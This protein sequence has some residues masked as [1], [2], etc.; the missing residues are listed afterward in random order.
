MKSVEILISNYN[1]GPVIELNIESIRARTDYPNYSIIVHDDSTEGIDY[2]GPDA[3]HTDRAYLE[4]VEAKG[5]IRLIRSTTRERWEKDKANFG[6]GT[7]PAA[8][9][10]GCAVNVLI[11]ETC[12]ADYAMLLDCDV[13]ITDP[14]WLSRMIAF[15]DDKTLVASHEWQPGWRQS[16]IYI[17]GWCRPTFLMLNMAV[18]HDGME[19]DWRGGSSTID[20]EPFK[21][22]L[23]MGWSGQRDNPICGDGVAFDPGSSLWVQMKVN[24]PKN[25]KSV[26]LPREMELKYHHFNNGSLR[27]LAPHERLL[28]DKELAL[29]RGRS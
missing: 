20:R 17:P 4:Q 8:Y 5:W 12:R 29:I 15:M 26:N 14:T 10:H 6:P 21:T 19:V 27:S 24:N 3:L 28:V 9:Y 22:L 7:H 1:V 2:R 18:Y 13:F 23:A 25:Y 16:G 11:N